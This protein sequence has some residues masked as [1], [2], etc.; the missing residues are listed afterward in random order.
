MKILP[1]SGIILFNVDKCC[2]QLLAGMSC[3][4]MMKPTCTKL[5]HVN[6]LQTLIG[7]CDLFNDAVSSGNI[8]S[9]GTIISEKLIGNDIESGCGLI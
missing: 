4:V 7:G 5:K 3:L 2:R 8:V 1:K 9:N 6:N